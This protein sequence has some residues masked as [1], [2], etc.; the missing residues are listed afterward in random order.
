[1]R[2]DSSFSDIKGASGGKEI[3]L[4]TFDVFLWPIVEVMKTRVEEWSR[5]QVIESVLE[6]ESI[7]GYFHRSSKGDKAELQ[8]RAARA[9]DL[10]LVADVVEE[11]FGNLYAL[12]NGALVL[13]EEETL[14]IPKRIRTLDSYFHHSEDQTG[15]VAFAEEESKKTIAS[16]T[17]KFLRGKSL[18]ELQLKE[19]LVKDFIERR[20]LGR[21]LKVIN[22][23]LKKA[24]Y[25]KMVL[26]SEDVVSCNDDGT[27]E[28]TE[29]LEEARQTVE[30]HYG[31]HGWAFIASRI[32][33]YFCR[34]REGA[35]QRI[36]Q[37]VTGRLVFD[38]TAVLSLIGLSLILVKK[39][40]SDRK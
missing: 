31:H 13:T 12:S 8:Y 32:S 25:V 15:P 11:R 18:N 2:F 14:S 6:H 17:V 23:Y 29:D 5:S 20:G 26:E 35:R 1:M 7:K 30:E 10:L 38:I 24:D 37:R 34:V 9:F 40:G 19:K 33:S 36:G 21:N 22:A 16:K 28:L 4:P 27:I 3:I 39:V